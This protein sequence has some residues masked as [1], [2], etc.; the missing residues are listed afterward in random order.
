M[1]IKHEDRLTRANVPSQADQLRSLITPAFVAQCSKWTPK[2][3]TLHTIIVT[4]T[5]CHHVGIEWNERYGHNWI[6]YVIELG[7]H[8][9]DWC[10]TC[11][12]RTHLLT[13]SIWGLTKSPSW[14]NDAFGTDKPCVWWD[15]GICPLWLNGLQTYTALIGWFLNGA[16]GQVPVAPVV[17]RWVS[18]PSWFGNWDSFLIKL[19]VVLPW[20]NLR[21]SNTVDTF[22]WVRLVP[23]HPTSSFS[24]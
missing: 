23:W 17:L 24:L 13:C 20:P 18:H 12:K 2:S 16:M 5:P 9:W 15:H 11:Q 1:I 6:V 22:S 21:P 8:L 3:P 14:A 7:S 10:L 4:S 19:V